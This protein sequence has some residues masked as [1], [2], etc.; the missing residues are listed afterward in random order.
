MPQPSLHALCDD[1]VR[2]Y[3]DVEVAAFFQK[4]GEQRGFYTVSMKEDFK[5]IY[6]EG[7]RQLA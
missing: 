7:A 1:T 3:G 5:T 6:K 4:K 2:D